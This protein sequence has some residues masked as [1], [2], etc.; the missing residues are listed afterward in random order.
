MTHIPSPEIG[1]EYFQETIAETI[2]TDSTRYVGCV[3]SPA[4]MPRLAELALES[5][6]L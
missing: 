4:Q 1:T 5:T 2:F 3:T 6:W